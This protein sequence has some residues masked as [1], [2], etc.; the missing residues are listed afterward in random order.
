MALSKDW[1]RRKQQVVTQPFVHAVTRSAIPVVLS[2][3]NE[4]DNPIIFANDSFLEMTGYPEEEVLGRNCRF[5]QGADTDRAV[6]ASLRE[7]LRAL[8]SVSV[9]LKNYRKDG[10]AF[11]NELHVAP[12]FGAN[13]EV[14]YFIGSQVDVTER[15]EARERLEESHEDLE[16]RVEERTRQLEGA[17]EQSALLARE[18]AHR[19][20]N[21]LT[22]LASLVE[23]QRRSVREPGAHAI[24][25]EML[26]RI[27]AV[28]RIQGVLEE[29]AVGDRAVELT[30]V[31]E[32]LREDLDRIA[33][34]EVRLEA[35]ADLRV[36]PET[37]LPLAL[38]VTELVL[39]AEKHA[40]AGCGGAVTIRLDRPDGEA[41]IAVE[42]DGCGL[43]DG[44]DPRRSR[45]T[46][47]LVV[48][49]QVE[50]VGGR[51]EVGTGA[52]GGA[53][54]RLYVPLTDGATDA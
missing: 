31:L 39:N 7:A 48:R 16:R 24:L 14:I 5:L 46:G 22:L 50:Q 12:V 33:L 8:E 45:G 44:F 27:R 2:D 3:P 35:G 1:L 47:M 19:V 51:V 36:R 29:V 34:A 18:V 30:R 41:M 38:A 20:R 49:T 37:A 32:T 43:P 52:A 25:G 40:F 13:G 6:L 53:S 26:G 23:L 9:E 10:S 11:W 15:V 17:A 4:D 28:A 54:F 21:S 42:D